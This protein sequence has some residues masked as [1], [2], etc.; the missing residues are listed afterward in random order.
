VIF[1]W[2]VPTFQREKWHIGRV[3]VQMIL[4]TALVL[5]NQNGTFPFT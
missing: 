5:V 1:I 3:A 2:T 4:S